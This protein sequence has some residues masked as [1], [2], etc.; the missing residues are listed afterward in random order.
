M[1]IEMQRKKDCIEKRLF[2]Y[3]GQLSSLKDEKNLLPLV[4]IAVCSWGNPKEVI[5]NV[6]GG[7]LDKESNGALPIFQETIYLQTASSPIGKNDSQRK[8]ERKR[9][10]DI[11]KTSLRQRYP[12][13]IKD[14]ESFKSL[15][16]PQEGDDVKTQIEKRN[17]RTAHEV[18]CFLRLAPLTPQLADVGFDK[19][20][21]PDKAEQLG[22]NILRTRIF[23]PEIREAYNLMKTNNVNTP[24]AQEQYL[25]IWS[26]QERIKEM[27]QTAQQN[28]VNSI[29]DSALSATKYMENESIANFANDIFSK[30]ENLEISDE[31]IAKIENKASE[32]GREEV[33]NIFRTAY[34]R[35]LGV[36]QDRSDE[37]LDQAALT[38]SSSVK[39]PERD[40]LPPRERTPNK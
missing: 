18:L 38:D 25:G 12:E 31:I 16:V 33:A 14:G 26:E 24:G 4:S 5:R 8:S 30:L 22:E 34:S 2:Q 10:K 15:S 27:E 20:Q 37:N 29:V 13:L 23:N 7:V 40:E 28:T 32:F 19:D 11:F 6:L 3:E 17:L 36:R 9:I 1:D 35:I 21:N 39:K